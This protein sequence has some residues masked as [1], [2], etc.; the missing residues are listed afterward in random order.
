MRLCINILVLTS[1]L[2]SLNAQEVIKSLESTV[3]VRADGTLTVDEKIV[4]TS[5]QH[6]IK[7]GIIRSFPTRYSLYGIFGSNVDFTVTSVRHN[8]ASVPYQLVKTFSAHEIH[9]GDDTLLKPGTQIYEIS[10]STNRQL[11]FFKDHDELYWNAIGTDWEFPILKGSTVIQL[12]SDIP[13]GT[14][15]AQAYTG[16]YGEQNTD[17]RVSL[18]NTTVTFETTKPLN[19]HEGMTVV[20]TWP[21]GFIAE[22]SWLQKTIWFFQDNWIAFWVCLW[23]LMAFCIYLGLFIYSRRQRNPGI[24]IP[25]FYP[26]QSLAP[27][28]VGFIQEKEFS[29]SFIAPEIVHLAVNG[30][31]TIECPENLSLYIVT[32]TD[33][34]APEQSYE[35]PLLTA[36]FDTEKMITITPKNRPHIAAFKKLLERSINNKY[37]TSIEHYSAVSIIGLICFGIATIPLYVMY[38][39]AIFGYLVTIAALFSYATIR[40]TVRNYTPEGQKYADQIDGFKIFLETTETERL[41]IIGTPPVKTPELYEHYLPYAMVLGVEEAWTRQFTPLFTRLAQEHKPYQPLWYTGSRWNSRLF[42]RGFSTAV[43][44]SLPKAPG[45]S[46]GSGGAGFSG[47]GGGGGG[48]RGR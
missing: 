7:R 1:L 16:R 4:I 6:A 42:S 23:I 33:K 34:I 47:G 10:Y 31:I 30:Y 44:A 2:G 3:Y 9:I 35:A 45:R 15:T 43:N 24:I 8:N 20:L 11:G 22:P 40:K 14:I 48:G 46:S 37:G 18:K 25:L 19:T 29:D 32:R 21:K 39:T 38:E 27:S 41:K 17:Y 12:P 5:A 36:F 28:E 13:A 26:P